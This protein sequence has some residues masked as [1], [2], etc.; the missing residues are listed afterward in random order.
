[1][2]KFIIIRERGDGSSPAKEHLHE[3]VEFASLEEAQSYAGDL[4]S[5][6]LDGGC[7]GIGTDD[8]TYFRAV[9]YDEDIEKRLRR[10]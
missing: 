9:E 8:Y 5:R 2:K 1:M 7:I 4:S 3:V 6:E 10:I